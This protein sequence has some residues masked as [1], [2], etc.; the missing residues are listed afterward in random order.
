MSNRGGR[1]RTRNQVAS[2]LI[3]VPVSTPDSLEKS[4]SDLRLGMAEMRGMLDE[5][6]RYFSY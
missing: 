5:G 3:E 4:S 1:P 2:I 6:G